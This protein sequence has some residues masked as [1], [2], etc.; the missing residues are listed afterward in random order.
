MAD[1][2]N[3]K[4]KN[5]LRTA[6]EHLDTAQQ[7]WRDDSYAARDY[8]VHYLSGLAVECTLRAY[9]RR[10]TD[11]FDSRHDLREL[12]REA[13]FFLLI[14]PKQQEEYNSYFNTLNLRWRS[15]HRFST[16]HE[17]QQ[18]LKAAKAEWNSKGD[19]MHNSSRTMFNMALKIVE[20]GETKW[21]VKP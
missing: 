15:N 11:Q 10:R 5:Y 7:M 14:S 9:I 13:K 4:A 17:V 18:H 21:Q 1:A 16:M 8:W 20:L 3:S 19:L 12:A 6:R 2:D